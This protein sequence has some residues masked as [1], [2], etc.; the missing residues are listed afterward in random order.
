M[1]KLKNRR[2]RKNIYTSSDQS[3]TV[4]TDTDDVYTQTDDRDTHEQVYDKSEATHKVYD[5]NC[6]DSC[7]TNDEHGINDNSMD[8]AD[9]V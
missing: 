9:D 3:E 6:V 8:E 7:H 4:T 1:N 5:E 2:E